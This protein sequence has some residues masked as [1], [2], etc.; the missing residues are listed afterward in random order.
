MVQIHAPPSRYRRIASSPEPEEPDQQGIGDV[1]VAV[2][3]GPGSGENDDFARL[4]GAFPESSAKRSTP[5][6]SEIISRWNHYLY[7]GL[8]RLDREKVLETISLPE[9][10]PGLAGPLLNQE[11]VHLLPETKIQIDAIKSRIQ[12]EIGLGLSSLGSAL[13][14]LL[15]KK[16]AEDDPII[17]S[18]AN[19]AKLLSNAHHLL[20]IHRR[21]SARTHLNPAI[22]RICKNMKIDAYLFGEDFAGKCKASQDAQKASKDLAAKPKPPAAIAGPSRLSRRSLNYRPQTIRTRLKSAVIQPP[23][24]TY[25]RRQEKERRETRNFR[26]GRQ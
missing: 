3:E 16:R 24:S 5:L 25:Q 21:A 20:S 9:N 10:C 15:S 19:S 14:E 2:E 17:I 13:N 18:L 4:L 6:H 8:D 26:R 23:R 22:Q 11:L 1:G 12:A 7:N